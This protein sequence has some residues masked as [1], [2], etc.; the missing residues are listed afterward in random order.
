MANA[1]VLLVEDSVDNQALIKTMLKK[2]GADVF[3]AGDGEVG[4]KFATN[5]DFDVVLMDIQ[6]PKMDGHAATRALRASGYSGPII[7]LTAHAMK[8]EQARCRESG[9]T[10]FLSKPV[11]REALGRM[12][13]R[14]RPR[15]SAGGAM[16]IRLSTSV[17]LDGDF[18]LM[19]PA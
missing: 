12:I 10:D 15:P 13:A 1:Q 5:G 7:A 16:V 4:V 2:M 9:F 8:E 17:G 18:D 11:E 3:L 6:M 19:P 14:H